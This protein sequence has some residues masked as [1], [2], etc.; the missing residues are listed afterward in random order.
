[1]LGVCDVILI[2]MIEYLDRHRQIGR[3]DMGESFR[4]RLLDFQCQCSKGCSIV[5]RYYI[6]YSECFRAHCANSFPPGTGIP[7]CEPKKKQSLD[8]A[9]RGGSR[10]V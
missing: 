8:T 9:E 7:L 3:I 4:S 1:M 2:D 5:P 6:N 10:T